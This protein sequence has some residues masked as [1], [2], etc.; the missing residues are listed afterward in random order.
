MKMNEREI[1]E[2]LLL[3]NRGVESPVMRLFAAD[4][5]A[6]VFA[7]IFDRG[8]LRRLDM[9]P[10]MARFP[11]A[12]SQEYVFSAAGRIRYYAL[13]R[14]VVAAAQETATHQQCEE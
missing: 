7:E 3:R 1:V 4:I 10:A 14:M 8:Y 12:H 13:D 6:S 2:Y 5:V 11:Y 9:I